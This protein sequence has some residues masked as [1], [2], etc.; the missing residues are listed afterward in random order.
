M[1]VP[2]GTQHSQELQIL[3]KLNGEF[4]TETL[5]TCRFVPLIGTEGF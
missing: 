3:R 4:T 5:E 1:V 2:V